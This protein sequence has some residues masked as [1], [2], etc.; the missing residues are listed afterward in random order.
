MQCKEPLSRYATALT[1][2]SFCQV[3]PGA[4][5]EFLVEHTVPLLTDST[6]VIARRGAAEI[7]FRMLF[8]YSCF[9]RKKKIKQTSA[10]ISSWS[11]C[12]SWFS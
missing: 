12:P 8:F 5:F 2:A 7:L 10:Q 11:C 9:E 3:E 6:D 4:T 1:M